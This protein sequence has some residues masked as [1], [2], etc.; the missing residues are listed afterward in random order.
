MTIDIEMLVGIWLYVIE[1]MKS[2]DSEMLIWD[3]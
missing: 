2:V 3:E 1:N